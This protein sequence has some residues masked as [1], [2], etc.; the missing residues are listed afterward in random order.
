MGR[1][2]S[3]IDDRSIHLLYGEGLSDA[4]FLS[5]LKSVFISRGVGFQIKADG[6]DGGDPTHILRKC[7][8]YRRRAEFASR[9]VLI[10]TDRPW[11]RETVLAL[12][13]QENVR[14]LPS[15]P[16]L[17]GLLLRILG[18]AVPSSSRDCKRIF[19]REHLSELK[20]MSAANYQPL[21]PR[22]L[23]TARAGEI[24]TLA[25][26]IRFLETGEAP[27]TILPDA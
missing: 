6:D 18:K 26:L 14:M 21:F 20:M 16:C 19:Q 24:P 1:P 13:E 7:I 8:N 10:D 11:D 5:H 4:A 17:E 22:D 9:T 2:V 23:L 12:A 3:S 27:E 15:Q 25:A